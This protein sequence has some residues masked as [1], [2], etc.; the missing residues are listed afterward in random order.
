MTVY[1]ENLISSVTVGSGGASSIDFTSIPQTYTDLVVRWS[2]R[3]T[4][5]TVYDQVYVKFNNTTSNLSYLR[6]SGTGSAAQSTSGSD[7]YTGAGQG[8]ASTANTFDNGEIYITN[9]TSSNYKSFYSDEISENNATSAS[10]S[11]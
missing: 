6:L 8:S 10:G 2:T 3:G 11:F 5:A 1:A 7:G 9:Y 4:A